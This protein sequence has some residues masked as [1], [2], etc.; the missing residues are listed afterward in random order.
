M[1]RRA[2]EYL[3]GGSLKY[4][5]VYFKIRIFKCSYHIY[6]DNIYIPLYIFPY[7][8]IYLFKTSGSHA[9]QPSPWS[10]GNAKGHWYLPGRHQ[11]NQVGARGHVIFLAVVAVITV[12][13][14]VITSISWGITTIVIMLLLLSFILLSLLYVYTHTNPHEYNWIYSHAYNIWWLELYPKVPEA[15][16]L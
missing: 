15:T 9:T 7:I 12:I 16:Q 8:Y 1:A 2:K 6:I 10:I 13:A 3:P 14:M 4:L 11:R 5:L